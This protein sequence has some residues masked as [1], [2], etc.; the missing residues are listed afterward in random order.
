M[1]QVQLNL[2]HNNFYCPVTGEQICGDEMANT[3]VASVRFIYLPEAEDFETIH[4]DLEAIADR[5]RDDLAAKEEADE[6]F[7]AEFF[8][9]FKEALEK[10]EANDS[11]V[12]YSIT[13]KGMGCG[14][15]AETIHIGIDMDYETDCEIDE[16][17]EEE[18]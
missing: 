6:D 7:C 8:D 17:G 12:I 1:Q 3:D 14:P 5:I 18:E 10:D 11:L 13:T 4:P 2:S 16:D 9:E 15:I